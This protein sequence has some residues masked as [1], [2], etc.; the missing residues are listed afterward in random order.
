MKILRSPVRMSGC[1]ASSAPHIEATIW[2]SNLEDGFF[3]FATFKLSFQVLNSLSWP[4]TNSSVTSWRISSDS[5]SKF[6]RAVAP[7]AIAFDVTSAEVTINCLDLYQHLPKGAVWILRDG[8]PTPPTVPP[9][10]EG[11]TIR[12]YEIHWFPLIRPA[13]KPGY[14]WGGVGGRGWLICHNSIYEAT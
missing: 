4:C 11:L 12:A 10:K 2:K 6:F 14:F 13:I 7:A 1:K 3:W 5:S 9:Q 8:Q